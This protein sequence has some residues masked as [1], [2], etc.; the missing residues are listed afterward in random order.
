MADVVAMSTGEETQLEAKRLEDRNIVIP[1]PNAST[2]DIASTLVRFFGMN[3]RHDLSRYSEHVLNLIPANKTGCPYKWRY[4]QGFVLGFQTYHS[5]PLSIRASIFY[6]CSSIAI[7]DL[8]CRECP[9]LV[10]GVIIQNLKRPNRPSAIAFHIN[11]FAGITPNALNQAASIVKLQPWLR[12]YIVN[13]ATLFIIFKNSKQTLF[14]CKLHTSCLSNLNN[15]RPTLTYCFDLLFYACRAGK[16]T[17][18]SLFVGWLTNGRDGVFTHDH[19]PDTW[20]IESDL[21]DDNWGGPRRMY[22]DKTYLYTWRPHDSDNFHYVMM[23]YGDC[24]WHCFYDHEQCERKFPVSSLKLQLGRM[25]IQ[26]LF[27][28]IGWG[29]DVPFSIIKRMF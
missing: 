22:K 11:K 25:G 19:L 2:E 27:S 24:T 16:M 8:L 17:F 7:S 9:E 6:N 29:M 15:P 12:K 4:C 14:A 18:D 13:A 5:K 3:I 10:R 1:H 28:T 26:E 20:D 21:Y 23:V